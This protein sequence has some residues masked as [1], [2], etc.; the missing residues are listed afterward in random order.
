V[1]SSK[2]DNEFYNTKSAYFPEKNTDSREMIKRINEMATIA[3]ES[4]VR[5][6]IGYVV[7]RTDIDKFELSVYDPEYR[8]TV[9][10]AAARGVYVMPI[11]V[12]WTNDG[13]AI[14]VTDE[15]PVIKPI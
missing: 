10:R 5:C 6:I 15:L 9:K 13:N 2:Y 14:F 7:E 4:S 1:P 3:S 8:M 11:V 12:S